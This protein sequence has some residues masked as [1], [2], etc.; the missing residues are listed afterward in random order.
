[1]SDTTTKPRKRASPAM[2]EPVTRASNRR[3]KQA[4][5]ASTETISWTA[6]PPRPRMR[7]WFWPASIYTAFLITTGLIAFQQWTAAVL[8]VAAAVAFVLNYALKPR[9]QHHSLTGTTL[10]IQNRTYDLT[11]Y[12]RYVLG[13]RGTDI[14]PDDPPYIKLL[15]KAYFEMEVWVLLPKDEEAARHALGTLVRAH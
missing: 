1:M 15:P 13:G 11:K 5:A 3:V 10:T 14:D 9:P 2:P 6:T 4:K 7:W 8:S 12:D